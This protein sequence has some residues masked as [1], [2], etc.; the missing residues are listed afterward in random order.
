MIKTLTPHRFR[1]I[2]VLAVGLVP[3]LLGCSPQPASQAAQDKAGP[4]NWKMTSTFA[5]SLPVLG[6]GGKRIERRIEE[7]SDGNV[8]IKLFELGVLAPALESFDAV[9]YGAIEAAWSTPGYWAGKVPALQLF[10]AVPFGPDVA[11]YLAWLDY[12]GGREL[13]EEIYH[14]YNIHGIICGVSPPEASGWFKKEILTVEDFRGLK[15]RFFGLGA[16]VVEKLGASTQLLAGGDVFPAL[17]LGTID[18]AEYSTPSVDLALGFN[19]A[20]SHYYFPG[21]HQQASFFELM[22]NLQAWNGLSEVQK[23]QI[24]NVCSDNIRYT[25]SEGGALQAAALRELQRA[26]V[27][28]HQWPEPILEAL[29]QAW[30]EVAREMAAEDDDFRRAWTSLQDFRQEYRNWRERGY[31]D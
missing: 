30:R 10:G 24:E 26:G 1:A 11:E 7:I 19:Q 4:V 9:A 13:F 14:K 17:E 8:R 28:L 20:A 3:T 5:T 16:K 21:W 25:I 12:G 2:L 29:R 6:T 15:I 22:I 23:A 31:L 18:A 27:N